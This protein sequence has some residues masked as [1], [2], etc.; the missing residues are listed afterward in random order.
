ME[1]IFGSLE[2]KSETRL[3]SIAVNFFSEEQPDTP[4]YHK[5]KGAFLGELKIEPFDEKLKRCK[6]K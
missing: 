3:S 6:S 2:I 4:F 1:A 5:M